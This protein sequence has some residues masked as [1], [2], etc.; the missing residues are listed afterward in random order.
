MR[1]LP[2][3][4]SP[5]QAPQCHPVLWLHGQFVRLQTTFVSSVDAASLAPLVAIVHHKATL[6]LGCVGYCVL[7]REQTT[8]VSS[9]DAALS[10]RCWS[11]LC[12]TMPPCSLG[13]VCFC[14]LLLGADDV[15]ELRGRGL[16][17]AAGPDRAPRPARAQ[18]GDQK[19]AAQI[20]GNMV[21]LVT[22]HNDMLPYVPCC[23][24]SSN[25]VLLDQHPDVRGSQ[26]GH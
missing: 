17:S 13:C 9:V 3:P 1:S 12:T 22:D 14:V 26:R 19:K 8:F 23:S 7:L 11:S 25:K 10:W 15:C 6:I 20:V 24:P 16:P 21:T 4:T 5:G 2:D 18:R